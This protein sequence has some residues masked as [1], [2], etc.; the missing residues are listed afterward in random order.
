MGSPRLIPYRPSPWGPSPLSLSPS[1]RR[2]GGSTDT[3]SVLTPSS[4][5]AIFGGKHGKGMLPRDSMGLCSSLILLT[6]GEKQKLRVIGICLGFVGSQL[7]WSIPAAAQPPSCACRHLPAWEGAV[8]VTSPERG[9]N[10]LGEGLGT[11]H[12]FLIQLWASQPKSFDPWCQKAGR[13]PADAT[14]LVEAPGRRAPRSRA[15]VFSPVLHL[16]GGLSFHIRPNP[17]CS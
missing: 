11:P 13:A 9:R 4:L 10:P 16:D 6:C 12:S 1:P 14:G 5:G 15:L 3:H 7:A 2:W 8:G 17:S